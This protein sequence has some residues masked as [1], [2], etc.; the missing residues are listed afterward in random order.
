MMKRKITH[1]DNKNYKR[2]DNCNK[3]KTTK[4]LLISMKLKRLK[5]LINSNNRLQHKIIKNRFNKKN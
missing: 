5:K 2:K 1:L 3:K 4:N